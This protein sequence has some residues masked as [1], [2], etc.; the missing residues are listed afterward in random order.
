[1]HGKWWLGLLLVVVLMG[2][3]K[4][5]E[6]D[7]FDLNAALGGV[8]DARFTRVLAPRAF[9]FPQDHAAHPDFRNEWW[10][11]TGNVQTDDGRQFGYQVTWFRIALTPDKPVSVSPWASN[12]VWMAHV[13]LTDVQAGEHLHE[14]RLARGAAGLA[15]QSVQPFRVWLEDWQMVGDGAG[16]FPWAIAVKAKDFTLNLQ[17][18]PQKPPVLQG[19]QGL[20]QKSSEVGNASYYYSLT[21]LQTLGEIYRDGQRFTVTGESWLDREWSTSALGTDQAGWDWFSLQLHDGHEVMFYRLRKKSGETDAHSA[22]KWVLPEGAAQTLASDDVKLKPLRYWQAASGARYPVA[23][24]MSLRQQGKRWR[25]EAVVDDQLMETG[26]TY[27]EGAVRVVDA[28]NGKLLGQ[29][30]LEMSGYQ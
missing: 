23:W 24:E 2:C 28:D 5:P 13:A 8:A 21:R 4:A 26:I 12:Q 22:G 6:P 3:S 17:L 19:D 27:W 20:S 1:M 30:Y 10:Y 29:G 25:I 7:A 15:G 16:E 14:Q 9:Q 18:R 11:V